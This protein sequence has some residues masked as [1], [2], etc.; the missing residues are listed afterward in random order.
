MKVPVNK[1]CK[2]FDKAMITY[3]DD[4]FSNELRFYFE[5][6]FK[7]KYI[8]WTETPDMSYAQFVNS[9]SEKEV[10]IAFGVL[11]NSQFAA[12]GRMNML[13]KICNRSLQEKRKEAQEREAIR[14]QMFRG[15]FG[16]ERELFP[17]AREEARL[18]AGH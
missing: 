6:D 7:N 16:K 5:R 1:F 9:L 8:D 4:D 2:C 10:F 12:F 15:T 3:N 18:A 14:L 17:I 11:K 13:H